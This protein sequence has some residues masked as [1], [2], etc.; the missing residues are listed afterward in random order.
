MW[1]H[2]QPGARPPKVLADLFEAVVGAV[3]LQ[4][5]F[6]ALDNWLRTIF[7]PILNAATKDYCHSRTRTLAFYRGHRT[8]T[9]GRAPSFQH[10]LVEYIRAE[11]KFFEDRLSDA[12][13]TLPK[14]TIFCFDEHEYLEEPDNERLEVAAHFLNL[15]ICHTIIRIWPQYGHAKAKA[16]HLASVL[17]GVEPSIYFSTVFSFP[18][19]PADKLLLSELISSDLTL[20]YL[21]STLPLATRINGDVRQVMWKSPELYQLP[22]SA[23]QLS[24]IFKATIGWYYRA[25]PRSSASWA[26]EWL[27]PLVIQS[28]A[29]LVQDPRYA[30]KRWRSSGKTVLSCDR[31]VRYQ[32]IMPHEDDPDGEG[33]GEVFFTEIG[34]GGEEDSL[35]D[36][37]NGLRSLCI[38]G[39]AV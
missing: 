9:F 23:H 17:T 8:S 38:K 6:L 22:G 14:N 5:G 21:A 34:G 32:P 39:P 19:Q 4:H 3:F 2:L 35:S 16:A 24:L 27:R 18:G 33:L 25:R 15:S 37:S 20:S 13:R 30:N 29:L 1:D 28:H 7:E 12:L 26:Y 31:Y 36:L 10:R 11:R